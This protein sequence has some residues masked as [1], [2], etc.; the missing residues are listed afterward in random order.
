MNPWKSSR[1]DCLTKHEYDLVAAVQFL[2]DNP[3]TIPFKKE[4]GFSYYNLQ[5]ILNGSHDPKNFPSIQSQPE[6]NMANPVPKNVITRNAKHPVKKD[7]TKS[8]LFK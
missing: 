2:M 4:N 1:K 3:E 7:A 5:L 8:T 6:V